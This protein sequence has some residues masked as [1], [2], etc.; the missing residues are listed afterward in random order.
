MS[1]PDLG[2]R[3]VS[4]DERVYPNPGDFDPTRY[5]NPDGTLTDLKKLGDTYFFGFGRRFVFLALLC[6][7]VSDFRRAFP[8]ENVLVAM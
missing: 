6:V 7:L 2:Y 4:N 8:T 3:A 1:C 5:L